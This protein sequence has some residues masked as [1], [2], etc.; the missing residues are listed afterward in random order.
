MVIGRI[1]QEVRQFVIQITQE[2]KLLI[3]R[4]RIFLLGH[5]FVLIMLH[6]LQNYKLIN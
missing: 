5:N 4:N 2:Q 1:N 6:N 3:L